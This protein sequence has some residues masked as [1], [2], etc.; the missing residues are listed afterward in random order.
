VLAVATGIGDDLPGERRQRHDMNS[1][2]LGALAGDGPDG[3][4]LAQLLAVHAANFAQPL[5]EQQQQFQ[6]RGDYPALGLCGSPEGGNLGVGQHTVARSRL[7]RSVNPDA[8]AAAETTLLHE[9][10]KHLAQRGEHRRRARVVRTVDAALQTRHASGSRLL[11][12]RVDVVSRDSGDGAILPAVGETLWS[13][14]A[15]DLNTEQPRP[16]FPR[17]Q[18]APGVLLDEVGCGAGESVGVGNLVF[19][20]DAFGLGDHVAPLGA[21]AVD[22]RR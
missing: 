12:Q 22:L 5:A 16:L 2:V 14:R 3:A 20:L 4:V 19:G 21:L 11:D 10:G 15:V 13:D 8:R 7:P 6:D 1:S 18:A 17:P 9:P